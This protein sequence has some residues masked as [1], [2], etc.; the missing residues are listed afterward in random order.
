MK[1]SKGFEQLATV[2]TVKLTAAP[3]DWGN[4][5]FPSG[6]S[7]MEEVAQDLDDNCS[8]EPYFRWTGFG[9]NCYME[10]LKQIERSH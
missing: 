1:N 5:Y 3:K 7:T 10:A 4:L 8:N 9:G 2:E 6:F